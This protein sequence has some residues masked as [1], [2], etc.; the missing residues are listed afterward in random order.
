MKPDDIR[1]LAIKHTIKVGKATRRELLRSIQQGAGNQQY[2]AAT[3]QKC[4][5]SVSAC[6][7]LIAS[8]S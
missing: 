7:A 1:E 8:E 4:A 5:D 6:G 2:F 3:I